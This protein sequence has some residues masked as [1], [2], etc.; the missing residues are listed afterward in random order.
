MNEATHAS[1]SSAPA[2]EFSR[3]RRRCEKQLLALITLGNPHVM[4]EHVENN[5][6]RICRKLFVQGSD[7]AV[8]EGKHYAAALAKLVCQTGLESGLDERASYLFIDDLLKSVNSAESIGTLWLCIHDMLTHFCNEVYCIKTKDYS[9]A[10]RQCSDHIHANIRK[11]MSLNELGEVCHR[12][13]HYV[14]DLFRSETGV[15]AVQ[16]AN[17]IKIQYA[18]YLLEYSA[19]GIAELAATLSYPSHSHFS[20]RFK[21]TY[22]V[23]PYEY[24]HMFK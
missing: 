11:A 7:D 23:T 6:E 2:S 10:V 24:R 8:E 17:Q 15:G 9:P 22:G 21:N 12:S 18:K 4:T 19:L 1:E 20:R 3:N 13:P 5:A 14:S 16:Y